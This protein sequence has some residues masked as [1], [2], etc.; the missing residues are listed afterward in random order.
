MKNISFQLTTPQIRARTKTVT[1]R[2]GW[3][4]LK[5]GEVLGAVEKGMGLKKGEKVNRL[6][7]IKTVHVRREKLRKM[8]DDLDYGRAEC[9]REGFP[10]MSPAEFVAMFCASH[11]KCTPES[12]VT[13]IKFEYV[14]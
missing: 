12:E 3:E 7:T 5:A 2:L 13:R 4:K 9:V 1:R 11:K 10:E 6:G 8:T 14:N